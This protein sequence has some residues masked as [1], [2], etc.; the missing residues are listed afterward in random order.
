MRSRLLLPI[1]SPPTL[2]LQVS[3][4][5][6]GIYRQLLS[7]L[8][9]SPSCALTQF[10]N[11][12]PPRTLVCRIPVPASR[13]HAQILPVHIRTG[14][15]GTMIDRASGLSPEYSADGMT[16]CGNL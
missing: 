6:T 10:S 13:S 8:D 7:Y 11:T 4:N 5:G 2:L 12:L 1:P 15:A 16:S 3:V 9:Y 14:Q